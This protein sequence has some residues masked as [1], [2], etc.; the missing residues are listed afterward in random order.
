[1]DLSPLSTSGKPVAIL[2]ALAAELA[3]MTKGLNT[4]ETW[5]QEGFSARRGQLDQRDVLLVQTGMGKH[6]ALRAAE[7]VAHLMPLDAMISVG[8]AGAVREGYRVGDVV[9]PDALYCWEGG[10]GPAPL[11]EAILPDPGLLCSAAQ[12]L[13]VRGMR[14][15]VGSSLT[16][17]TPVVDP[18]EKKHLGEMLQV[19][20]VEMESYWVGQ[21]AAA[22]Q[23]P[24]LA[25]RSILDTANQTVPH[26]GGLSA[27]AQGIAWGAVAHHLLRKPSDVPRLLRLLWA[28]RQSEKG[29]TLALRALLTCTNRLDGRE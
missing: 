12:T 2:A 24:F 18:D 15:Q 28:A 22:R 6:S 7:W 4:R 26:I 3:G 13:R 29:L 17:P 8:F 9:I 10:S 21:L 14:Y 16:V 20:I 1:M 11:R 27:S 23:V 19:Q 25:I 5:R